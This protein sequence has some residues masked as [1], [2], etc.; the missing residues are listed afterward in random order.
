MV[1]YIIRRLLQSIPLLFI[2]SIMIFVLL[3]SSGDPLASMG[4]R[5]LTRPE[6]RAR[7]ARIMGLD[8]PIY[9]QYIYWLV[10]NDFVQVDIDNDGTPETYGQRKGVLRGDFGNSLVN[11]GKS[12]LDLIKERLPN[13]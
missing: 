4:G 7:L 3:Q 10:G 11:R 13:T 2:I 1:R 8:Q 6:D 5:R 9:L 12:A